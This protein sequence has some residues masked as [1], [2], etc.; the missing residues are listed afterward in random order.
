[1]ITFFAG[2]EPTFRLLKGMRAI[3]HDSEIAVVANTSD[4]LWMSGHHLAPTLDASILLF[5]GLLNTSAWRGIRGDSYATSRF[6]EKLGREEFIRIGD[7]ERAMQIARAEMLHSG[8]PLTE[9]AEAFASVFHI[10]ATILPMTDIPVAAYAETDQGPVHILAHGQWAGEKIRGVTVQADEEAVTTEKVVSCIEKSDA[11]IIGPENP[12]TTIAPILG[13][14]G[15][16]ESLRETFVIVIS[17]VSGPSPPLRETR[18]FMEAEGFPPTSA[19]AY[20]LYREIAD[21]FVMDMGDPDHVE[22]ATRL[23]LSPGTRAAGESL[24][25][26]LL[27]LVRGR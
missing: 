15:V 22:G 1:M 2:S 21:C 5:A 11:V 25:W 26:D 4:A 10:D 27:S 16:K 7:K 6:L 3:L 20:G 12:F 24:A 9:I 8:S 18:K 23:P 19:G 17:P 14:G 13:C